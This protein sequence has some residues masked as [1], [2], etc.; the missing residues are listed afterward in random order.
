VLLLRYGQER[1]RADL[2]QRIREAVHGEPPRPPEAQ[3]LA[4]EA[5]AVIRH[6]M[7]RLAGQDRQTYTL[8]YM[9][10]YKGMTVRELA[11]LQGVSR[12][13]V[14][15]SLMRAKATLRTVYQAALIAQEHDTQ[16]RVNRTP[17][18]LAVRLCKGGRKGV[19]NR[20]SRKNAAAAGQLS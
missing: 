1:L 12:S 7:Q 4:E 14:A 5:L 15:R 13:A 11:G 10:V 18:G 19:H 16:V 2:Q 20:R 8:L 6:S 17:P 3:D 9:H